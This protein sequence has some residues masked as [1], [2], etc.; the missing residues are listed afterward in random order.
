MCRINH[1][2]NEDLLPRAVIWFV[3]E[4]EVN[5]EWDNEWDNEWGNNELGGIDAHLA[6]LEPLF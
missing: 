3:E 5:E 6:P 4:E 1:N 2:A